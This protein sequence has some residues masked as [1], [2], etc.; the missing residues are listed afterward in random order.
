M[1]VRGSASLPPALKPFVKMLW[2]SDESAR[3]SDGPI[4]RERVLPTAWRITSRTSSRSGTR[5][6]DRRRNL[7]RTLL[8]IIVKENTSSVDGESG[9]REMSKFRQSIE[10]TILIS[11][12]AR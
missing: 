10:A 4:A 11:S 7:T 8:G 1:I 9:A 12:I 5:C 3:T 6:H 2:F